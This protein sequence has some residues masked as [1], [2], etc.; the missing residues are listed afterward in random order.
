MLNFAL[1]FVPLVVGFSSSGH[2]PVGTTTQ[3]FVMPSRVFRVRRN[4]MVGHNPGLIQSLSQG[5]LPGLSAWVEVGGIASS[6]C[7]RASLPQPIS[8]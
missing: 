5:L 4:G 1:V 3:K 2:E 8:I 7:S 6:L